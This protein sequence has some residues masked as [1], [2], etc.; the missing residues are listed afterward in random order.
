MPGDG[1]TF[2]I[3]V[4]TITG[5]PD[6]SRCLATIELAASRV[7]G[8]V[9]VTD[10]SR[11]PRPPFDLVASTTRWH[12]H[13]GLS[14]YQL[15]EIGFRL[16]RGP[17]VAVTEDHVIVP[18]DW[19]ERYLDA[20]AASPRAIAI[21]GSVEN[22]ATASLVDWAAFL[23]TLGA[24]AAPIES[25]PVSR[26][27][28]AVNVAYRAEALQDVDDHGGLGVPDWLHQ[29]D[30]LERGGFLLADD[31]IRVAHDQSYNLARFTALH[32]HAGR[33]VGGFLRR[34]LDRRARLRLLAVGLIPYVR[35]GR[36]IGLLNTRG[37]G[38]IVRRAW[39]IMIWLLYAQ[40]A[41]QFI[42]SLV[43][44]GNSPRRVP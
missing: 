18:P 4:S 1:P 28:G 25:G 13:P 32:F 22:G 20:F 16:A 5:W 11:S 15:R 34:D 9:I 6:I 33:T 43:G 7:G 27:A 40:T 41:G 29:R 10:G 14:I 26:L 35:F 44:P 17:I 36:L 31:T 12:R 23:V 19:G 30:M 38:P 21:G 24:I 8:E 2:S 3:S 42:G 37:H 39:P